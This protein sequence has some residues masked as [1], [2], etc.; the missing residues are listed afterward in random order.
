[1]RWMRSPY[2]P[3]SLSPDGLLVSYL[4]D[5]ATG[6]GR[7]TTLRVAVLAVDRSLWRGT[8]PGRLLRLVA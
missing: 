6:D 5:D 4:F 3:R 7:T 1:M 2:A 8:L